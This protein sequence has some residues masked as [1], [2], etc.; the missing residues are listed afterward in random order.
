M[1]FSHVLDRHALSLVRTT[2]DTLQVNI[3]RHCNLTCRHCH[4]EAGPERSE[5]M[6]AGTVE[7]V[8]ACSERLGFTTIDITGGAPELLPHLPRLISGLRPH[9]PRLMVRCNLTALATEA[10]EPLIDLYRRNRV[11]II[12]SL[13]SLN[14]SQIEAQR[15][16]GVRAASLAML[17]RLN[18]AGFGIE[19][20]G[21]TLDI[22]ANPTGAFLPSPQRETEQ[23]FR[24]ELRE[25]HGISFSSLFTFTNVPLGRFLGWLEQ[26]GNLPEYLDTLHANF[27]PGA[28]AGLMCRSFLSVDWQ[29]Y[30]YDCDF[31]QAAGLYHRAE[32]THISALT[33][34]PSAGLPI[35]TGDHCFACTAGAGFTCGGAIAA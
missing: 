15:G 7:Q 17:Q 33:S 5:L 16:S 10:A 13:P 12:A 30:L 3:G 8:I 22:A 21:L 14:L 6:S 23:R 31:N 25:R 20:S 19:G 2:T 27:N 29:G 24:R 28:V 11:A 32:K 1:T 4:L 26:S 34:L 9:T 35:P 18:A